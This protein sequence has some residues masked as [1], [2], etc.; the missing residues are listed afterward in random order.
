[1]TEQQKESLTTEFQGLNLTRYI[2]EAVSLVVVNECIYCKHWLQASAVAE[3]K[4]KVS[5][6]TM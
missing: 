6:S 1:M 3:A 5:E 4:L 2:Q